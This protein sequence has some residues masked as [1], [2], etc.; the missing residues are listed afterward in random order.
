MSDGRKKG[1][2]GPPGK[3]LTHPRSPRYQADLMGVAVRL[4]KDRIDLA[5]QIV[6]SREEHALRD[7]RVAPVKLSEVI[8]HVV[9]LGM[10]ELQVREAVQRMT[11]KGRPYTLPEVADH[12]RLPE[13]L[14]RKEL[15]ARGVQV[16]PPITVEAPW[17]QFD[18]PAP[19]PELT[20]DAVFVEHPKPPSA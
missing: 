2:G 16:P 4:P 3:D 20:K 10:Y 8:R 15:A 5:L 13:S 11:R 17:P 18:P 6:R 19:E 9:D 1:G 14:L 7:G 12:V